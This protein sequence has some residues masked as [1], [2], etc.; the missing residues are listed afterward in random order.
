MLVKITTSK[1]IIIDKQKNPKTLRLNSNLDI[2]II[3][4]VKKKS[5]D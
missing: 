5:S 4:I 3:V 1:P 2:P